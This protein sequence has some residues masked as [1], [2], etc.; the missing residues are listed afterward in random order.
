MK[1][2]KL[3]R[4]DLGRER[5][6]EEVFQWKD[7]KIGQIY[8]QFRRLGASADWEHAKFTMDPDLCV[9]VNEA[10]VRLY[11]DGSIYRANRLVNWCTKLKTALSNLEVIFDILLFILLG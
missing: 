8:N 2:R 7:Q 5:F 4:H 1:E 11:E 9:A 6:L 3:T 10:F